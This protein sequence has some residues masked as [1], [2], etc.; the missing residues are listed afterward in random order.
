MGKRVVD[1]TDVELDDLADEAWSA[2]AREALAQG[3]TITGSR[4]G[5]RFRCHPNGRM[6]DLGPVET[7]QEDVEVVD[8]KTSR[9]QPVE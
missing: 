9:R 4:N 1:L 8:R 5:R 3:L 7:P 6:E 2:A